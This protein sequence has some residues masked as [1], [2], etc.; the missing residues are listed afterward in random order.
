MSRIVNLTPHDIVVIDASGSRRVLPSS[1][2]ARVNEEATVV[3]KVDGIPLVAKKYL[4]ATGLPPP[5]DGTLYVVSYYTRACCPH[6]EDLLVPH[7]LVR[8]DAGNIV[9][10]RAF[11]IRENVRLST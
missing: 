3:S 7:D 1:G 2:K 11:S 9:G 5:E 6:R 10:C 8:D 4:D